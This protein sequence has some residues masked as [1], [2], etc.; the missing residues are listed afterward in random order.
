MRKLKI[1]HAYEKIMKGNDDLK[2]R[3]RNAISAIPAD[4]LH[5]T[6]QELE[7]GLDVLRTTKVDEIQVYS[8]H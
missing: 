3:I 5:S 1:I 6:W 4:M 8:S 7:Y 2:T